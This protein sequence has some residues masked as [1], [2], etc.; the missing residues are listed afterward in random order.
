[1]KIKSCARG[2]EGKALLKE[3]ISLNKELQVMFGPAYL[4]D[5]Q[6]IFGTQG[7]PPKED[8]RKILKR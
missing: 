6:E 4:L 7:V 5:N 2:E 8:F 1:M 3:N